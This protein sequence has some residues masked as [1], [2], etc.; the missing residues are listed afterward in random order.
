[1]PYWKPTRLEYLIQS[2]KEHGDPEKC[3]EW[4]FTRTRGGYGLVRYDRKLQAVHRI[5]F[6]LSVGP[7]PEGQWVRHKCDNRGCY[8]PHH[9]ELGDRAANV[10]DMMARGRYKNGWKEGQKFPVLVTPNLADFLAETVRAH[11]L[12]DSCLEWPASLDGRGYG[13]VSFQG[14]RA[15]VSRVAYELFYGIAPGRLHVLHRCD[16][17]KCYAAAHLFLGT[18]ADNMADKIAKGR[19]RHHSK[20]TALE[21]D[22]IR[23]RYKRGDSVADMASDFRVCRGTI[24]ACV[25]GITWKQFGQGIRRGLARGSNSGTAKFTE[26]DIAAIRNRYRR[27]AVGKSSV[28]LAKEFKVTPSTIVRI[29]KRQTWTHI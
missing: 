15:T 18:N 6:R 11:G 10:A 24:R 2:I 20:L 25:Q 8:S 4:P 29:V 23:H 1:M 13:Q 21:A 19:D 14:R 16:N 17:R 22:E 28:A 9:L 5:A 3:L 12:S 7:I 26:S 27:Y